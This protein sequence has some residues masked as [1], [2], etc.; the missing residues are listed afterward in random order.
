MNMTMEE[1]R[2]V[3]RT[4][5]EESGGGKA[6]QDL[7]EE[8]NKMRS[9]AILDEVSPLPQEVA[10]QDAE[11]RKMEEDPKYIKSQRGSLIHV[12]PSGTEVGDANEW[13]TVCT[14]TYARFG[15]YEIV[16]KDCPGTWCTR[17]LESEGKK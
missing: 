9:K 10:K 16:G 1:I 4:A 11:E 2:K 17:C 7:K 6:I 8:V 3:V 12:V 13:R 5:L 14:W 15:R